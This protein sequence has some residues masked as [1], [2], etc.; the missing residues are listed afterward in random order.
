MVKF[1]FTIFINLAYATHQN[2]CYKIFKI[3]FMNYTMKHNI[4]WH[5]LA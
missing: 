3:K 1:S 5:Y 4:K 2:I